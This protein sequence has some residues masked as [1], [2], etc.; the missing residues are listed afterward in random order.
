ML[1][2]QKAPAKVNFGLRILSKR[3]D[4]YH[5]LETIFCPVKLYDEISVDIKAASKGSI[6]VKTNAG[7]S[8]DG[9][10]NI[11]YRTAQVFLKELNISGNY[12]IAIKIKKNIPHGAGLGGGSSDAA[13]LL[14]IL[15]R[16][17]RISDTSKLQKIALALGSDVPF[18]IAGKP[19]YA[20]GRGEKLQLRPQ[21]RIRGKL[22][23]VNPGIHIPTPWAFKELDL[24]KN[25]R[26]IQKGIEK[27][28]PDDTRLMVNDFER[29]VFKKYPEIE[30]IK[31]DMISLGAEFALM[32]GSGS[33][34]YG[35]FSGKNIR[36][37]ER[38]FEG[39]GYNVFA[40]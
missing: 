2:K 6:S 20:T 9:K 36:N 30:M 23:L 35:I 4:S 32:S 1:I 29:V 7:G 25:K 39:K 27:F 28:D 31:L 13:A 8:L 37:A 33:T 34:V 3:K 10:N 15:A 19:A 16:Y 14:K 18:F 17:F 26:A 12:R 24:K 22:L 38:F 40:A 11:C 5:N 21:F